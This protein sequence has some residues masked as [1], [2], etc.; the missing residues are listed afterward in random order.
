[1]ASGAT[2]LHRMRSLIVAQSAVE[3]AL[4]LAYDA[5]AD[6]GKEEVPTP[7]VEKEVF[8]WTST[9]GFKRPSDLTS[10]RRARNL[11][12]H[13]GMAPTA[14]D[15]GRHLAVAAKTAAGVARAVWGLA[16]D[17]LTYIDVVRS[18]EWK[19]DLLNAEG[20]L[21]DDEFVPSL[22][23]GKMPKPPSSPEER[24]SLAVSF[25]RLVFEQSVRA[26]GWHSAEDDPVDFDPDQYKDPQFAAEIL[27]SKMVATHYLR[28]D[29]LA[30][31]LGVALPDLRRFEGV[32]YTVVSRFD[33]HMVRTAMFPPPT[34][35]DA[36]FAVEFAT[37]WVLRM[38][39]HVPDGQL[40]S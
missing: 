3:I 29:V 23:S 15:L 20:L 35:E 12:A 14:T 11:V 24:R 8:G 27:A 18:T 19:R 5:V 34:R 33:Q 28:G 6:Q 37:D 30:L 21:H 7:A 2:D 1:M 39:H 13:A 32:K 25:A 17:R 38:E 22:V 9:R 36:C 31:A 16:L 4:R 10:L 26:A 40:G